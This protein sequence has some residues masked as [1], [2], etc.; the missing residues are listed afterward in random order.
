MDDTYEKSELKI[1][2]DL[3]TGHI[4]EII[5]KMAESKNKFAKLIEDAKLEG[6]NPNKVLYFEGIYD[7]ISL[8]LEPLKKY[9]ENK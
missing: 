3:K 2:Y 9:N 6:N 5:E 1:G 7:G 4:N 8:M